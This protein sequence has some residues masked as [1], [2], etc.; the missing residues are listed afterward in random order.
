M[1]KLLCLSLASAFSLGLV[2]G[3]GSDD[4]G[5]GSGGS[6]GAT[7]GTSGTGGASTGGASG[8]GGSA[9]GGAAGAG[10]SATGGAAGGGG[11]AGS[12][13]AAGGGGAAGSG[14]SATGGTGG[15][16]TGGTGTGGTGTGGSASFWPN[17]F[18]ANCKPTKSSPGSHSGFQGM[19]C[20][21]CHK[22][23]G[24]A[25]GGKEWLFGGVVWTTSAATAGAP[26]VEIGIK[27]GTNFIYACTDSKGL[28][29]APVAGNTAPNWAS[30][31]IH[32]RSA[33]GDKKMN[34]ASI[35][36]GSCN[37]STCHGNAPKLV[38]P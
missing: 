27:D 9:T 38:I 1:N 15:T 5:G 7:G 10:G 21:S 13:G 11:V 6:G 22:T 24:A 31:E 29:M 35:Q 4:S 18:D 28:F 34:T 26:G 30:A 12:G 25:G 14:G 8:S 37:A 2:A 3:C 36:A 33:T 16:G 17:A 20:L 19:E 23:G 32:M